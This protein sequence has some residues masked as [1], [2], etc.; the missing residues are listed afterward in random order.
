[1]KYLE[2]INYVSKADFVV[3][4][5]GGLRQEME[6]LG[7]PLII[8]RAN[9]EYQISGVSSLRLTNWDTGKLIE[10][11]KNNQQLATESVSEFSSPSSEIVRIL[12]Q[13]IT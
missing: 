10:F 13:F 9:I 2:F 3:T 5:S 8:H 4:D 1:M 12:R 11:M 6:H 7:K